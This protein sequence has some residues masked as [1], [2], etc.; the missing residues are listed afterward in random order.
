MDGFISLIIPFIVVAVAVKMVDAVAK[1][2]ED[3]MHAIPGLPDKVERP[4]SYL[5][6]FI[7][8]YVFCWR[9]HFSFFTYLDCRFDHEWE[10]WILT[11]LVLSGGS[12]F[13]QASWGLISTIP[14]NVGGAYAAIRGRVMGNSYGT[15]AGPMWP[16]VSGGTTMPQD[17]AGEDL[18]ESGV[19]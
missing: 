2:L 6:V 18:K 3:V 7:L 11:A 16:V 1:W 8:S 19:K 10:G 13:A 4:F 14:F 15:W 12:A 17:L 9:A 5:V